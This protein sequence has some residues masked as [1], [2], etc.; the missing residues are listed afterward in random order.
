LRGEPVDDDEIRREIAPCFVD[1]G[2]SRTDTVVLACTHYPLILDHLQ[3]L[4]PWPV[5][6]LDPAPAIARRTSQL[7]G[8]EGPK[9]EGR[10]R[11]YFTSGKAP[12]AALELALTEFGLVAAEPLREP[13]VV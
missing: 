7:L 8:P 6:W 4:A 11:A 10:G 2:G 3:K 12:S 13:H 1:E 9:T 5:T